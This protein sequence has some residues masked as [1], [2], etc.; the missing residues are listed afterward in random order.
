MYFPDVENTYFTDFEKTSLTY[1]KNTYFTDVE[2]TYF[3]DF[4]KTSLKYVKNTYFTDVENTYFSGH[5]FYG[6]ISTVHKFTYSTSQKFGH[7][8]SFKG[9]SLFFVFSTL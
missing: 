5:C 6:Q 9:F 3:T 4:E 8:F 2:N 1:V 7:T